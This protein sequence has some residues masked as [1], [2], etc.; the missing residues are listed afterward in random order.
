MVREGRRPIPADL[1]DRIVS[2][3]KSG[4]T[5]GQITRY[6]NNTGVPPHQGGIAWYRG[7]VRAILI[8]LGVYAPRARH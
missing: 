5:L 2:L 4:W 1:A 6:L 8:R 7:T 3:H